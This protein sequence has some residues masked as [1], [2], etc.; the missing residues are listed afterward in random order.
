MLAIYLVLVMSEKPTQKK[1][2]V[3][4]KTHKKRFSATDYK[5]FFA[6]YAFY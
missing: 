6:S 3:L 1:V 2:S 4:L 5:H